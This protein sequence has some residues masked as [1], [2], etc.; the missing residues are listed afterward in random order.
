MKKQLFILLAVLATTFASGQVIPDFVPTVTGQAWVER[1]TPPPFAIIG[2]KYLDTDGLYY[3]YDGSSWI[4]DILPQTLTIVGD[5]LSISRGN[6]VTLPTTGGSAFDP[7]ADQYISGAWRFGLPTSQTPGRDVEIDKASANSMLVNGTLLVPRLA[8]EPALSTAGIYFNTTSQKW[9]LGGEF[10]WIDPLLETGTVQTGT[11]LTDGYTFQ[12]SDFTYNNTKTFYYD[13]VTD[14]EVNLLDVTVEG[15]LLKIWQQNSDKI[16]IK[17]AD[18]VTGVSFS[19][20]DNSN[21]VTLTKQFNS[22]GYRPVGNWELYVPVTYFYEYADAANPNNEANALPPNV[23]LLGSVTPSI[24]TVSVDNGIYAIK[25][26]RT[27]GS[28]SS[29]YKWEMGSNFIIG[30]SYTITF[31]ALVVAGT[32]GYFAAGVVSG[33]GWSSATDE[34][35]INLSAGTGA[36]QTYSVTGTASTI[37]GGFSVRTNGSADNGA[38]IIIDN[39]IVTPI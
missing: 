13:G 37:T 38:V 25:L 18:G 33:E 6:S 4:F 32:T 16:S 19:T 8:T 28:A 1:A 27:S 39:I 9:Y 15:K 26:T 7:T 12:A 23:T 36:Y 34:A 35:V 20:V 11:A 17:I 24:E 21:P 31:S 22:F 30:N 3:R 5:Q 14:I 2:Q 29:N 10:A